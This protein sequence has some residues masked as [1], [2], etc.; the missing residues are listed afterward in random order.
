MGIVYDVVRVD[1]ERSLALKLMT[2]VPSVEH[3]ARFA[4]EAK[5]AAS[6]EHP[7][8]VKVVDA[9]VANGGFLFLAMELVEGTVLSRMKHRAGQV[10][11]AVATI[12]QIARGLAAIHAQGIVHRDLKPGTV[13]VLDEGDDTPAEVKIT[14]FGISVGQEPSR[15]EDDAPLTVTGHLLGTPVYMAPE[16]LRDARVATAASDIYS[17]GV[18]AFEILHGARPFDE[19]GAAARAA[20]LPGDEPDSFAGLLGDAALEG[21]LDRALSADPAQRPTAAAL[22]DTAAR[23][24]ERVRKTQRRASSASSVHASQ[25][26]PKSSAN[27]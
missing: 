21:M 23:A 17:L 24:L 14:D 6:L 25:P 26:P 10:V 18:L 12:E 27:Q 4:R 1:D 19:V 7:N 22:A 9:G 20:G 11:W 8:V 5:L 15:P 13:I 16:V 3:M 2:G